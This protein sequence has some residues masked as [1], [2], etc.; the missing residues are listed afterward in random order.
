MTC[1]CAGTAPGYPQHESYCGQR[2]VECDCAAAGVWP[3]TDAH[4]TCCAVMAPNE[5]YP[6]PMVS[7]D[8]LTQVA[9]DPWTNPGAVVAE[10][11]GPN[12]Q[13]SAKEN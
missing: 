3:Y 11:L 9:D 6:A 4:E 13:N 8:L 1:T 2:E 7:A 10:S 5:R 12:Q